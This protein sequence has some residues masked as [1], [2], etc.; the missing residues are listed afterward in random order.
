MK[1]SDIT[2]VVNV[3]KELVEQYLKIYN[4]YV[5]EENLRLDLMLNPIELDNYIQPF[6]K[7]VI[8]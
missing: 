2:T 1:I 5:G 7:K 3:S 8:A 6:K 4:K